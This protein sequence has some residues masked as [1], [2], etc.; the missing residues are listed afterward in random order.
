MDS[1]PDG[2]FSIHPI[3]RI[4]CPE[5]PHNTLEISPDRKR[6]GKRE[7]IT[8]SVHSFIAS[9]QLSS[10]HLLSRIRISIPP[11]TDI[12]VIIFFL[13][14][15]FTSVKSMQKMPAGFI[16]FLKGSDM[17]KQGKMLWEQFAGDA[18][19]PDEVFPGQSL[20]EIINDRRVLIENHG[21]IKEYGSEKICVKLKFG[22]A[23]IFGTSL[24]IRCMTRSK[25][26]ICGCIQC[27][28]LNRG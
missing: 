18:D 14:M 15:C 1:A 5:S 19:L 23:T 24:T 4:I 3:N 26:V 25:L 13:F 17:M 12:L 20:I 10:V 9:R 6:K 28:Q 27:I 22:V 2:I 21:G 7:G 11:K 8:V 16:Y